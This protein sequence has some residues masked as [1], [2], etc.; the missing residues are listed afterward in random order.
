MSLLALAFW[1]QFWLL[2]GLD[3]F[4]MRTELPF[5]IWFGR[6]R[7]DQFSNYFTRIG[8][9]DSWVKPV[10]NSA[11]I[12]EMI[13]GLICVV[14]IIMLYK[15]NSV[16]DKRNAVIY[17]LGSSAVL[18]IGFCAFDVIVGDRAELLEHSTYIGVIMACYIV[19]LVESRLILPEPGQMRKAQANVRFL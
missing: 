14:C 2:N 11:G 9:D 15:S 7:Q 3:K 19:A 16:V 1:A 10:L 4:L 8:I 12:L 18:F 5:L 17:A 13:T 6:D